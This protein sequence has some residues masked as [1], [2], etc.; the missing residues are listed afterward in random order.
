MSASGHGLNLV[1]ELA[2]AVGLADLEPLFSATLVACGVMALA[3]S[4]SRRLAAST[5]AGDH[6]T[7]PTGFSTRTIFEGIVEFV[8]KMNDM[9]LGHENRRY[10]PFCVTLFAF[11][12]FMN[13]FG[14][15]PG[16]SAP[17]DNIP[18][19][20]GL[21]LTAFVMYHVAG[22]RAVGVSH[23]VMHFFGPKFPGKPVFWVI[24]FILLFRV[25]MFAIELIS[26]SVRPLTLTL[27]LF[28][29]M[30]ADHSVLMAFMG[31]AG[32][33]LVPVIFYCFGAF[34]CLMQASVFTL[35]TMVYIKLAAGEED[36]H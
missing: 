21:A 25:F 6:L 33:F 7:P 5:R 13:L 1:E 34:V 27:R 22:V 26:H 29:N 31:L 23:Y 15:I 24:P 19:N 9:V 17:T 3:F 16:F 11:I 30:F 4:A 28:G 8:I 36:A 35:L 18:I 20:A 12:I 14:L 2:A 10:V 32:K